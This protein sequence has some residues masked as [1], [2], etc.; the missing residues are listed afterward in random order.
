MANGAV[1]RSELDDYTHRHEADHYAHAPMRHDLRS[2]YTGQ[3]AGVETRVKALET[4][5]QRLIGAGML[6]ALILTSGLV[7]LAVELAR[8]R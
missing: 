8:P 2:E 4:W 5:Q 6:A 3:T 7:T 1:L